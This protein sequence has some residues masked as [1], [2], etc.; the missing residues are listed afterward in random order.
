LWPQPLMTALEMSQ[1]GSLSQERNSTG[2]GV[3]TADNGA[4]EPYK[5]GYTFGS[6]PIIVC[7]RCF[8]RALVKTVLLTHVVIACL[9]LA[10]GFASIFGVCTKFHRAMPLLF[11]RLTTWFIVA[12]R[13]RHCFV[14]NRL[15]EIL[16][17]DMVYACHVPLPVVFSQE[18][19]TTCS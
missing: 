7:P 3:F 10:E 2:F 19:L 14:F 16:L 13:L 8:P 4:E 17:L 1:K 5:S 11:C 12:L 6:N 18:A 9:V 15:W